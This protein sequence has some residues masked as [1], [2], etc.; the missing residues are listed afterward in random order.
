MRLFMRFPQL[1]VIRAP[2]PLFIDVLKC[3]D[4]FSAKLLR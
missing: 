2:V 4:I 1:K 3:F